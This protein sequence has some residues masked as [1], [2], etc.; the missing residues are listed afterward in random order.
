MEDIK[1]ELRLVL[2]QLQKPSVLNSA[3]EHLARYECTVTFLSHCCE[4]AALMR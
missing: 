1:K 3:A 2:L 4:N